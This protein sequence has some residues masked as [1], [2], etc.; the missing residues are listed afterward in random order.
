MNV[1]LDRRNNYDTDLTIGAVNIEPS[2]SVKFLGVII[3]S[4][5]DFSDNVERT[6]S[7]CNSRLYIMRRL[8]VLGM[9]THG[10]KIFYCTC[11]RPV[12]TYAAPAWFYFLSDNLKNEMERV[13]KSATRIILPDRCYSE[14]VLLLGLPLVSDFILQSST[15]IFSKIAADPSHPLFSRVMPNVNRTSSRAPLLYRPAR[16]RTTKRS[17]SFFNFFMNLSNNS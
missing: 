17:K 1:T 10:L 5:L 11:V 16:T 7:K 14:R 9:N 15:T 4:N 3:D 12:L 2:K 13:Q 8:K 6:I